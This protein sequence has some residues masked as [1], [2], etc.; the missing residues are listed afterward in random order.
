MEETPEDDLAKLEERFLADLEQRPVPIDS[1]LG[2]LRFLRA[3]GQQEVAESWAQTLQEALVEL[4]DTAGLLRLLTVWAAWR[5]DGRGFSSFCQAVCKQASKERLW[6]AC[7]ASVAFG[8]IAP[9]E[10]LRR[11]E[12]LMALQPGAGCLDKTWGFGVVKRVDDFYKRMVVDFTLKPNHT[13]TLAYAAEALTRVEPEH[14]LA[15]RHRDPAAIAR[16]VAEDP[17]EV[18]RLALRSFGPLS[19]ARIETLLT[20]LKIVTP[21]D[22]KRFWDGARKVLKSDPLVDLPGKRTEPLTLRAAAISFDRAWFDGLQAERDTA[23]IMRLIASLEAAPQAAALDDHARAVLSD[24]LAFAVK[25]AYRSDAALYA[26]LALMVRRLR[27]ETPPAA[28]LRDHLW[29]EERFVRAAETLPARDCGQMV[30]LLLDEPEAPARLLAPLPRMTYNLLSATIEGLLAT[31]AAPMAKARCRELLAAAAVPPALLVWTLRNRA[32]VEGWTLPTTYELLAHAIAII[33]DR[34]LG[35]ESLR[36][37]HQLRALFEN[38]KWFQASFAALD[39]I[40]Q[41]AIFDRIYGNV[42]LW[43]PATQRTL[44]GRM[45]NLVPALATRKHAAAPVETNTARWTSWRSLRERREQFKQLLEVD[46]PRNSQDLAVARSHGDLRENFEFQ[47][48]KQQQGVLLGRRDQW[49]L[50]LKQ[51]RGTNFEEADSSVAGMGVEV[52]FARADGGRQRIAILG[53]WDHDEALGIV[54]NRSR[55]ALALEGRRAGDQAVIPGVQGDETVTI[56][57]VEPLGEAVRAWVGTPAGTD[58]N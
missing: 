2:M 16:L 38:A 45:V 25:G 49:D 4:G 13:L 9:S 7:I 36:M 5:G 51:M 47:A 14:L 18:V 44:V 56:L 29:E 54:A 6:S 43:D 41:E 17:A 55:L 21:A 48:A 52:L 40:Q 42:M 8:E 33:E 10:S 30:A 19:V 1:L 11:L 27:L 20:D 50:D 28:E 22:W 37:Q 46:I 26:R 12:L 24:R 58:T 39:G 15:R 53:E 31:D 3:S 32:L 35:G 57:A 23:A 34:T